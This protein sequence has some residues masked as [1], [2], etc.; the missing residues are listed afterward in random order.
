MI[1]NCFLL[2]FGVIQE[3][4][5]FIRNV[6]APTNFLKWKITSSMTWATM[7]AITINYCCGLCISSALVKTIKPS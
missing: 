1:S 3:L 5:R 2:D 4:L 7:I 6:L